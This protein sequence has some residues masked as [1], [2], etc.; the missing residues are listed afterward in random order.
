LFTAKLLKPK[1]HDIPYVQTQ[2]WEHKKQ[3]PH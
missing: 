2:F 1:I 3:Y